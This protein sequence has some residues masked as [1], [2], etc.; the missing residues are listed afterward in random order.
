MATIYLS[1]TCAD[2]VDFRRTV[3]DA[4]TSE[5]PYKHPWPN[6]EAF[7]FLQQQAGLKFD[8]DC[9]QAL[10]KQVEDIEHI[11]RRFCENAYG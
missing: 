6:A 8:R 7:A 9:V 3:F 5:R 1:S 10:L 4:L 2:L 11:Q